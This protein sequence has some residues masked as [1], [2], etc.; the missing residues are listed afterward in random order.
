M[1]ILERRGE[2]EG[3]RGLRSGGEEGREEGREKGRK[4]GTEPYVHISLRERNEPRESKACDSG[5]NIR[6]LPTSSPSQP[7]PCLRPPSLPPSLDPERCELPVAGPDC[8]AARLE[9]RR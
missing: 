5:L 6:F 2:T 3:V 8:L 7:H 9:D 4:D 1:G